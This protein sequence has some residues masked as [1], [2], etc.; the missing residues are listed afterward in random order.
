MRVIGYPNQDHRHT[1]VPRILRWLAEPEVASPVSP[2]VAAE[3]ATFPPAAAAFPGTLPPQPDAPY[4]PSFYIHRVEEEERALD[5]L[6]SPGTPVVLWGPWLSGKSTLLRHLLDSVRREDHA[7]GKQSLV[8]EVNLLDMLPRPATA[9][10]LLEQFARNLSREA[11]VADEAFEKLARGRQGW[12]DKLIELLEDHIL[13]AAQGRVLL[14][15]DKADAVW[16]LHD[17]QGSF[18]GALRRCKERASRPAWSSLRFVLLLSTTPSLV[19]EDPDHIDSPLGNLTEVIELL[20][21]VPDEIVTLA[22]MHGLDW[23]RGIVD[24]HV[25]PLVGGHPYLNR[26]LMY[27]ARRRGDAV[28]VLVN[29]AEVLE[30]IYGNHLGELGRLVE[31]DPR[32]REALEAI[33]DNPRAALDE[34]RYQRLRRAGLVIAAA[35]GEHRIRYRLYESYLRRRWKR[36]AR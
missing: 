31:R 33:L 26:A 29:D 34:D 32:L 24:R 4:D 11:H 17:V 3:V 19:F 14:V 35:N 28:N 23:D 22:W 9:D 18:Y 25:Y 2:T 5:R 6:A 20:E 36:L 12:S 16:G 10:G 30:R 13:P 15:V 27:R 8:L 1:E 7:A 21:L